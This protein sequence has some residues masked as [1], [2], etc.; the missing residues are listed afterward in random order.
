MVKGNF[1]KDYYMGSSYFGKILIRRP[2]LWE[3]SYLDSA[4]VHFLHIDFY[5]FYHAY[6][7]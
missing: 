4:R 7:T 1:D 6:D 5:I 3:A 2:P